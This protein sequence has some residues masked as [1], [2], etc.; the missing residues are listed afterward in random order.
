MTKFIT[1]AK[2][3]SWRTSEDRKSPIAPSISPTKMKAGSAASRPITKRCGVSWILPAD[4]C[5]KG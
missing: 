1:L 4:T 3:S 5:R 2:F